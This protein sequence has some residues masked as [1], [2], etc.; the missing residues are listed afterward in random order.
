MNFAGGIAGAIL[1][2]QMDNTP[3][4]IEQTR[5]PWNTAYLNPLQDATQNLYQTNKLNLPQIPSLPGAPD[6]ASNDAASG[7]ADSVVKAMQRSFSDPGGPLATIRGD[8]GAAQPGG[9][10]RQSLAEGIAA[11]REGLN[12][13]DVRAQIMNAIY[14]TNLNFNLQRYLSDIANTQWLYGQNLGQSTAQFQ[15]PWTNLINAGGILNST[16]G[17]GGTTTTQMPAT[18][19]WQT[20][21]GGAL[22]GSQLFKMMGPAG[23]AGAAGAAAG[24]SAAGGA[25]ATTAGYGAPLSV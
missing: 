14:P 4:P 24:A 8:F 1:G 18:P 9:G 5:S 17:L 25:G 2:K 12:E 15:A 21:L 13:G 6:L 22:A 19:W 3:G 23:A 7:Y 10:T 11:G 20:L 16:G